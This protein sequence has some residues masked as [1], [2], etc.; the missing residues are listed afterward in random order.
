MNASCMCELFPS[1]GRSGLVFCD[2]RDHYRSL[3]LA[4]RLFTDQ[5][6]TTGTF[7]E[8]VSQNSGGCVRKKRE[9]NSNWRSSTADALSVFPS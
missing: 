1:I 7:G 3:P 5:E 2:R 9:T 6:D 4:S 8:R